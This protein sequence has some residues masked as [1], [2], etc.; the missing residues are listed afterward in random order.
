MKI[1]LLTIKAEDEMFAMLKSN[2]SQ[3]EVVVVN[4]DESADFSILK[5]CDVAVNMVGA[6]RPNVQLL[7]ELDNNM[8]I[9]SDLA[10]I[11]LKTV[12]TFG[13]IDAL[14]KVA[15]ALT[16][17][18]PKLVLNVGYPIDMIT[19]YLYKAHQI[20]SYGLSTKASNL[21]QDFLTITKLGKVKDVKYKAAGR[22]GSNWIVEVTDSKGQ[23]L[24][25][26]AR[27]NVAD[28][29]LDVKRHALTKDSLRSL[30]FYGYYHSANT[31]EENIE[32]ACTGAIK[33][34]LGTQNSTIYL[35][36]IN[37]GHLEDFD[38][39][40]L[41][42]LPFDVALGKV[43]AQKVSLPL[44]CA[45]ALNDYISTLS[46]AVVALEKKSQTIFK[47]AIKL[48]PYLASILSLAELE[49][50]SRGL[51]SIYNLEKAFLQEAL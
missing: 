33:A 7:A 22:L 12:A 44:P 25:A 23:D 21:L 4:V 1:V 29:S 41:V 28:V 17:Y 45:L 48:D 39:E 15:T 42:E 19:L 5:G 8:G 46:V 43:D 31:P 26:Q 3:A 34:I 30:K 38:K 24:Y 20:V 40:A 32:T 10:E 27:A 18:Q 47:R 51:I 14:T 9:E 49:T 16:E 36:T 11:S 37:N 35:A 6:K 50:Y 2:F 13:I